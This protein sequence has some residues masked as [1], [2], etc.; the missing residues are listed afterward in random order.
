MNPVYVPFL[1]FLAVFLAVV[2]GN[3]LVADL[4]A[5]EKKRLRERLEEQIRKQQRDRAK[6]EFDSKELAKI[7]AEARAETKIEQ[8]WTQRLLFLIDQSGLDWSLKR[9]LGLT[10]TFAGCGGLVFGLL[11]RSLTGV[12]IGAV[13]AGV[14]PLFYVMLKRRS[15]LEKLREQLPDAFDLMA[16]VLR[17]G[18]TISQAMYAVAEEF[19]GPIALEFLYCYEQMNLGLPAETALRELGRRTGLL[20]IKIF[21]LSVIVHRQTG[22]NLAQLLDNLS[23]VV[24][25]RFRIRGMINSLTAQGR[26]QGMILLSLPVLMFVL[27]MVIQPEYEMLLLQYPI[28]IV[29]AL[30]MMGFGAAWI[31]KIVNFDY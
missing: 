5:S 22:G 16:R 29:A 31:R 2:S 18:Q 26:F 6:N 15:R 21:V 13:I 27:L 24:R 23:H 8:H 10:G 28:M 30:S 20:E 7:A 3:A 9:F 17:S 1:T 25:E 11:A 4:Y 14:I 12:F 19:S